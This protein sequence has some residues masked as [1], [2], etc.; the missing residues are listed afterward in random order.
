VHLRPACNNLEACCISDSTSFITPRLTVCCWLCL[1]VGSYVTDRPPPESTSSLSSSGDQAV[2]SKSSAGHEIPSTSSTTAATMPSGSLVASSHGDQSTS[3]ATVPS[4]S[5]P[6]TTA[7]LQPYVW[8]CLQRRP[9]QNRHHHCAVLLANSPCL[10]CL[11]PHM[12][13]RRLHRLACLVCL[14]RR[15]MLLPMAISQLRQ[16]PCHPHHQPL[17]WHLTSLWLHLVE[18]S[19]CHQLLLNSNAGCY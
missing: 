18:D 13:F 12:R 9:T 2:P 5:P 16:L 6:F 1:C 10:R 3:P 19:L 15:R 4:T 8:R 14:L 7:P 17:Q 11:Q